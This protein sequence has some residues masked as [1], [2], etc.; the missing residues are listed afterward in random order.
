MDS[1]RESI[2]VLKEPGLADSEIL[3]IMSDPLDGE[4][5][6]KTTHM[7]FQKLTAILTLRHSQSVKGR[8]VLSA[9]RNTPNQLGKSPQD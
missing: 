4:N 2:D 3:E 6:T 5:K 9:Q 8:R 1:F 7:N